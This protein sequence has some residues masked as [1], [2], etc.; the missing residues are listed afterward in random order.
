[1]VPGGPDSELQLRRLA[2]ALDIIA[3]HSPRHLRWLKRGVRTVFVARSRHGKV[4]W[5][6]LV[7]RGIL[8][9]PRWLW[10]SGPEDVALELVFVATLARVDRGTCRSYQLHLAYEDR[11]QDLAFAEKLSFAARL[12][13]GDRLV[14]NWRVWYDSRRLSKRADA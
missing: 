8:C 7:F 10:R 5:P 9:N 3:L 12:P 14:E 1:L 2:D 11:V 13:D 4:I 6:S